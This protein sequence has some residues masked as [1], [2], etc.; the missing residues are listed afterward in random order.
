MLADPAGHG[1]QGHQ[2]QGHYAMEMQTF[3]APT[4]DSTM[5]TDDVML[6]GHN[7]L[8]MDDMASQSHYISIWRNIW[9]R[10]VFCSQH[11]WS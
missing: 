7:G 11:L 6:D 1:L 3:M 8:G 2:G 5:H 4:M 9:I 10:D